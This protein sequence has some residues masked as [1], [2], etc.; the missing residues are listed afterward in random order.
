MIKDNLAILSDNIGRADKGAPLNLKSLSGSAAKHRKKKRRSDL[1]SLCS[2]GVHQAQPVDNDPK[3]RITANDGCWAE[4][5][6]NNPFRLFGFFDEF[7]T[8]HEG[9]GFTE[10]TLHSEFVRSR[11]HTIPV[12]EGSVRVRGYGE[13]SKDILVDIGEN[14]LAVSVDR[15]PRDARFEIRCVQSLEAGLR[16]RQAP[17]FRA[18]KLAA[19]HLPEI[20]ASEWVRM[21]D[22]ELLEAHLGRKGCYMVGL[23]DD[24]PDSSV[25]PESGLVYIGITSERSLK[26]RLKEFFISATTHAPG[27]SGGCEFRRVCIPEEAKRFLDWPIP[28]NTFVRLISV[29]CPKSKAHASAIHDLENRLIGAFAEQYSRL[30]L[31]NRRG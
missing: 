24:A 28:E 16:R 6:G 10:I 5:Q 2:F 11:F 14:E 21:D 1:C 9:S 30:P 23:F 4:V 17:S 27:H 29:A 25:F 7:R 19:S 15:L 12:P 3:F 18:G 13:D 22:L 8:R 31:C 26:L 20:A